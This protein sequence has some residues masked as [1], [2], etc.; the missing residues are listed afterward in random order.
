MHAGQLAQWIVLT[1]ERRLTH[2]VANRM[3]VG[4]PWLQVDRVR[5]CKNSATVQ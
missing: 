2:Q 4:R 3:A 1:T 5:G